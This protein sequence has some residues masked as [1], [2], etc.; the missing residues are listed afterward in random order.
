MDE[1]LATNGSLRDR[2]ESGHFRKDLLYRLKVARILV[3]PL[4]ER[5][6]DLPLLIEARRGRISI[7]RRDH[8][9]GQSRLKYI[10]NG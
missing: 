5:R 10:S 8:G 2:L 9:A 1:Q 6:D 3:P 7:D 4:H